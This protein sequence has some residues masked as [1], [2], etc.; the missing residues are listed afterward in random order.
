MARTSK[1]NGIGVQEG[2]GVMRKWM[3][4]QTMETG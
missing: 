1:Y 2:K 3:R 4:N